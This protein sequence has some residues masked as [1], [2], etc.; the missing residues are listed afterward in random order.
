MENPPSNRTKLNK[1][2]VK[3]IEDE[4]EHEPAKSSRI[5]ND[6]EVKNN[7]LAL[8]NINLSIN[9][10]DPR[11]SEKNNSNVSF[12]L[13]NI[14]YN[15]KHDSAKMVSEFKDDNNELIDE[16]FVPKCNF[17]FY[18][19]LSNNTFKPTSTKEQT[20]QVYDK[21]REQA[22]EKINIVYQIKKNMN[23]KTSSNSELSS[24]EDS[25]QEEYTS[26][27]NDS[28]L[29]SSSKKEESKIKSKLNDKEKLKSKV[30]LV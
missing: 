5:Y 22:L 23:K 4:D 27:Y 14:N 8:N 3:F 28:P 1:S 21:L 12:D 20:K 24:K 25:S 6:E 17:N 18:I 16:K 2:S 13:D 29:N 30:I 9:K 11:K 26:S 10:N 7:F 19:D 15:R